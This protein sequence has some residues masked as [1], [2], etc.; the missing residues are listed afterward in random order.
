MIFGK[1]GKPSSEKISKLS[2]NP[3]VSNLSDED[4]FGCGIFFFINKDNAM[5][6]TCMIPKDLSQLDARSFAEAAEKYAELLVYI[7]KG[8]FKNEINDILSETSSIE[9]ENSILF[10]QN[11]K[12][13]YEIHNSEISK[14]LKNNRP[15]ISPSSVF[16]I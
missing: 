14:I 16:R 12:D 13:F 2:S 15:L 7:N 1:F 10:I 9:N 11:V 4:V 3:E 5:E 6:I 8:L